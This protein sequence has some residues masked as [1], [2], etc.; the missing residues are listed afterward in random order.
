[1]C[2]AQEK[3]LTME[4]TN[5]CGFNKD[6]MIYRLQM[7]AFCDS[8]FAEDNNS[9]FSI[10]GFSIYLSRASI[11]FILRGKRDVTLHKRLKT[12]LH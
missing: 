8:D 11:S 7:K 12:W 2:W 4:I 6:D 5:K 1:M 3:C 9:N 10:T